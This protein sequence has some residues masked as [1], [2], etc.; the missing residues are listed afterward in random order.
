[1]TYLDTH[2][3][4][5]LYAGQIEQLGTGARE[6]VEQ[7]DLLISPAVVLELEYLKEIGR[8]KAAAPKII[9]ELAEDIGLR[10]CELPFS[11]IV[12]CALAEKWIRD[13]F[14]RLIVGHAKANE[15]PLVTK[16]AKIRQHYRRAVW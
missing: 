2:V 3:V 14:D 5:W 16:D 8:L 4:A 10:V 13:P 6:R 1:V 7:D 11:K 9:G 15:A 12:E